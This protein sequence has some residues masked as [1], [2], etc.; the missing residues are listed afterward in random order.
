MAVFDGAFFSLLHTNL[1]KAF[2]RVQA[3]RVSF[4]TS[5][6]NQCTYAVKCERAVCVYVWANH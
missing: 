3:Q 2:I 6:Y 1:I 5:D 4:Q